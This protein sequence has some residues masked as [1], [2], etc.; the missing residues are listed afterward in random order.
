M[1]TRAFENLMDS[2]ASDAIL[3]A[4]NRAYEETEVSMSARMTRAA[5]NAKWIANRLLGTVSDLRIALSTKIFARISE[6]EKFQT[7]SHEFAHIVD[8]CLRGTSD[9]GTTWRRIHRAMGGNGE[10]C[11]TFDTKGLRKPLTR[12]NKLK[13]LGV[14]VKV[15]EEKWQDGKR[16]SLKPATGFQ[17]AANDGK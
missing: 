1:F 3:E 16:I 12:W 10:R 5:G 13:H 7:V 9:H 4:A 11:H 17:I 8:A 15:A 2:G 14:Y 6:E